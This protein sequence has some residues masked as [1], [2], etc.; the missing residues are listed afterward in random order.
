MSLGRDDVVAGL[1]A[2]MSRF[3][4]LIASGTDD[5][6][7]APTRCEGWTVADVAAHITGVM[8]DITAGRLEGVDTQPWYDRQVAERRGRPKHDIV[9][10]LD[11]AIGAT[12]SLLE[13]LDGAAWS[14]PAAPGVDGTLGT[15]M[16][17]LWAGIYIH[18]E[19]VAAAMGRPPQRGPGLRAALDHVVDALTTRGW[20]PVTL[21][22]E[23][24]GVLDVGG[25]GR[26]ITTDAL[27]FVLVAS[28]RADPSILGV[29]DGVNV[30][31]ST[32]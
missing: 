18:A 19:D 13:I 4:A 7:A 15:A 28:G 26:R 10:E 3:R 1:P 32:E 5:E 24:V 14:G 12:A 31:A 8:A 17:G 23:D 25:G 20:G 16:Q 29:D 30:Y 6:W 27:M 21:E 11:A 2:E 22:L 9:E